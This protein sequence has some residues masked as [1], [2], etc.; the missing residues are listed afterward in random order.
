MNARAMNLAAA[1]IVNA[2]REFQALPKQSVHRCVSRYGG[3][4]PARHVV[5]VFTEGHPEG[6]YF[7]VDDLTRDKLEMGTSPEVLELDE[8]TFPEDEEFD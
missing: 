8:Y 4:W 7:E 6:R 2:L 5:L 1:G 3:G